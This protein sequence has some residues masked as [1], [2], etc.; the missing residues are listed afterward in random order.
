ML[1]KEEETAFTCRDGKKEFQPAETPVYPPGHRPT[2]SCCC[3]AGK[4]PRGAPAAVRGAGGEI[5]GSMRLDFAD[6]R[7]NLRG[8]MRNHRGWRLRASKATCTLQPTIVG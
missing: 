8:A 3:E 7:L 6:E 5:E 2:C 1:K 4:G